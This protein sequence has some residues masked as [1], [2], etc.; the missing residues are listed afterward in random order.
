VLVQKID[1]WKSWKD[2]IP[3]LMAERPVGD[4][5]DGYVS[6]LLFRGHRCASW[7]LGSTLERKGIELPEI[8]SYA[9]QIKAVKLG[10]VKNSV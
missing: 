1:S 10:G 5:D 3:G 4:A 2:I 9:R 7:N 6:D 8:H